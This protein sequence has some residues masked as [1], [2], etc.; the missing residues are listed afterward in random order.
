MNGARDDGLHDVRSL[1]ELFESLPRLS[2]C[3]N[4]DLSERNSIAIIVPVLNASSV[5]TARALAIPSKFSPPDKAQS[6]QT[7]CKPKCGQVAQVVERSPEKAGVG[8]STPS[9]ATII[10]SL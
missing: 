7:S 2:L 9:L 5:L 3:W 6:R 8:G 10:S 4:R 1:F